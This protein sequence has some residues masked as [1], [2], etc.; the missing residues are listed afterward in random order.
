MLAR[1]VLSQ[2][3][4]SFYSLVHR[5]NNWEGLIT[6]SVLTP[7]AI[8]FCPRAFK[9]AETHHK[10][11][12]FSAPVFSLYYTNQYCSKAFCCFCPPW[13]LF[14]S[15]FPCLEGPTA[16]LCHA[17]KFCSSPNAPCFSS[18]QENLLLALRNC[19][20]P[21]WRRLFILLV[22]ARWKLYPRVLRDVSVMDL[23]TS[24]L[25]QKIS[26]PLCVGATAMQRMA[27]ADGETATAKG[28]PCK[29]LLTASEGGTESF[30]ACCCDAQLGFLLLRLRPRLV[31]VAAQSSR[32]Y[33]L[34]FAWFLCRDAKCNMQWGNFEE[35]NWCEIQNLK[36]YICLYN[37]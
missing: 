12:Y 5:R 6:S 11:Y 19:K 37:L 9:E 23:S 22:C 34:L 25:G 10:C 26:M 3:P 17:V 36:L 1:L 13:I 7:S 32:A 4:V 29:V 14:A 30:C 28:K 18:Q 27:H 16:A 21:W 20:E 24:V 2:S 35:R 31:W 15:G 33:F 8:Q